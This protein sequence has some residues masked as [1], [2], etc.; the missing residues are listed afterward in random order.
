MQLHLSATTGHASHA[1]AQRRA[2]AGVLGAGFCFAI[3]AAL[4][5]ATKGSH[6][7]TFE[8]VVFRSVCIALVMTA[9][10]QRQ[11]GVLAALRTRRPGVHAVRTVLGFIAMTTGYVGYVRLPL[12]TA[13][14]LGFAMP[15]F[16]TLLSVPLLGERVGWRRGAAVL[17][18]FVGVLCVVRPWHASAADTPMD[19]VALVLAGV[20]AWALTM[21]TIRK[22]GNV[23]ERNAT[24]V[25]WYCLGSLVLSL[26]L[27]LPEWVTPGPLD[28]ALLVGAG[29]VTAAAQ[30]LM[31]D[32]YRSG[33]TTLIAPFEYAAIIHA[34][35]F[36]ALLWGEVPDA[37][38]FVGIAILVAAGLSIW[39]RE[40]AVRP[41]RAEPPM[42]DRELL[43]QFESLGDNCEFGLAQ[44]MLGGEPLGFFRFNWAALPALI[45][46][47]DDDFAEVMRAEQIEIYPDA[48]RDLMVRIRDYEF[49]Y[50]TQVREG[51][52]E[53]EV[54][55]AQQL[56]AIRFLARKLLAD[57]RSGEKV[58]VRKGRDSVSLDEMQRLLRALRRHG[59][60]TLL[61]VVVADAAHR[62]GTVEMVQPG[63]LKGY[64][65]R[66]A[67]YE[68]VPNFS[69][70]WLDVCRNAYRIWN[71]QKRIQAVPQGRPDPSRDYAALASATR[72]P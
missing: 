13:T 12:A 47:L 62:A 24:I 15:L 57:L 11:G 49:H 31:T 29:L 37:W 50:H 3:A 5:K 40:V 59:P 41:T 26:A 21:I 16:L 67:P 4:I 1:A 68:D 61:W 44:R 42:S 36:G 45:R 8:M 19:A 63:L 32:A 54:L 70:V 39:W 20:V 58:F 10:L 14:A 28:C 56:K 27:S 72:L 52:V 30:L 48:H 64:I 38:T 55:R 17:F 7:P 18:G 35:L 46:A 25:L 71:D 9:M 22:L 69:R 66:F 6:I 34:V 51:D 43:G 60:V 65:D 23:G 33:E 53:I 2:I